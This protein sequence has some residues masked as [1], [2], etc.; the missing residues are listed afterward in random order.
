MIIKIC[1]FFFFFFINSF[2]Y[3]FFWLHWVSVAAR[4]LVPSCGE[5]GLLFVEV[6]RLLIG[7]LLLSQ[8]TGS[9]RAGFS[10]CGTRAQ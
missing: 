10:S 4:R 8:S 5:R 2:I 3:L 7:L 1:F 6:R 9:R